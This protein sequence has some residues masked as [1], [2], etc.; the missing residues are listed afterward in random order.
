MYSYSAQRD[1]LFTHRQYLVL[2]FVVNLDPVHDS[3]TSVGVNF[4]SLHGEDE[5]DRGWGV[6]EGIPEADEILSS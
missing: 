5:I 6:D 4:S 2:Y 3:L 1:T